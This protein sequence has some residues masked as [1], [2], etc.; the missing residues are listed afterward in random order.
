MNV[1]GESGVAVVASGFEGVDDELH[2]LA[3]VSRDYEQRVVGLDDDQIA[4][5]DESDDSLR[6]LPCTSEIPRSHQS[7]AMKCAMASWWGAA[8]AAC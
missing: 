2:I 4:D 8:S 1:K 5:A 3:A 7:C 6:P